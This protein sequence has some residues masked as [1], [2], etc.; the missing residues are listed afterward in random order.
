[1]NL[2]II[3]RYYVEKWTE[4][5]KNKSNKKTEKNVKEEKKEVV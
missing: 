4:R 1:M 2:G 5:I 3:R